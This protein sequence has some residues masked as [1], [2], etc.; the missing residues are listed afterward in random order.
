MTEEEKKLA[1][2][3]RGKSITAIHFDEGYRANETMQT[4]T[5]LVVP[6]RHG[7]TPVFLHTPL[8]PVS[9][10]ALFINIHGG[11]FVR[12]LIETNIRFCDMLA[13]RTGMLVMDIDYLLA[14]EYKFPVAVEQVYDVVKW[15]FD[16]AGD[17]GVTPERIAMGGHSAGANLTLVTCMRALQTKDFLPRM[18]VLDFCAVDMD[19]PPSKKPEWE[20]NIIPLDRMNAFNALYTNNDPRITK[21]PFCSPKFAPDDWLK[22]LPETLVITGGRDTF[23]YEMEEF[24]ARMVA[25][26]VQVRICRFQGSDH[27]FTVNCTGKWREAQDLIVKTLNGLDK[28]V[29]A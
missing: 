19:T 23:R 12:P 5:R 28:E 26:G 27:G 6:S 18:M 4:C 21:D 15:I 11:G 13:V 25:Q 29:G 24:A 22:G 10:R 8:K 16:H 17:F 2:G 9:P 1:E 7:D 20:K 14:P 3:V